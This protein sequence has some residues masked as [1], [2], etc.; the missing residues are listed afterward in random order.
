MRRILLLE[1]PFSTFPQRGS[2]DYVQFEGFYRGKI[3]G[4]ALQNSTDRLV[5]DAAK[6]LPSVVFQAQNHSLAANSISLV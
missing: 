3:Q 4:V 2:N 5:C 1:V 6:N